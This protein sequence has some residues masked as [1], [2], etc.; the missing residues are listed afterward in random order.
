MSDEGI[1]DS[2]GRPEAAQYGG[3]TAG[4]SQSRFV[5]RLS[6][7]PPRPGTA[8]RPPTDPSPALPPASTRHTSPSRYGGK[9][10]G[11]SQSRFVSCLSPPP[12]R[13]GTAGR[14]PADP[15]PA[16]SPASPRHLPVPVRREDRRPIPVPL[17]LPPLPATP[18][19]PGTAGRPPTDPSPALSPASPRHLPVPFPA[20]LPRNPIAPRIKA[21]VSRDV[22]CSVAPAQGIPHP[23]S[24]GVPATTNHTVRAPR[25]LGRK[26]ITSTPGETSLD[27]IHS[28]V[29]KTHV[30]TLTSHEN[31]F[32]NKQILKRAFI[33][34]PHL[35]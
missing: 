34:S 33:S 22:L 16:L 28:A 5:S 7:P 19:R 8:G 26:P 18:P 31:D 13:P 10:T 30:S 2:D 21:A 24:G 17:C 14:P 27:A 6:P 32:A 25:S 9:T 4:R 3:K 35:G 23:H 29:P 11:R 15:S 1:E 12:P 20:R